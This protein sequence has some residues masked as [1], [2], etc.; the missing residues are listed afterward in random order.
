MSNE[1]E[2]EIKTLIET[3]VW[4]TLVNNEVSAGMRL[5]KDEFVVNDLMEKVSDEV[6]SII[7]EYIKDAD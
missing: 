4:N 3:A 2:S 5:P 1:Y 6:Y 7:W